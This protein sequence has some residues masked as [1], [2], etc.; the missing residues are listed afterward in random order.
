MSL[1][2]EEDCKRPYVEAEVE[3]VTN[4]ACLQYVHSLG[5]SRGNVSDNVEMGQEKEREVR[6]EDS[7]LRLMET[8]AG[9]VDRSAVSSDLWM[10]GDSLAV[11]KALKTSPCSSAALRGFSNDST[12]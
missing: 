6:F 3:E 5:N 11:A 4:Q 8:C 10:P 1:E 9:A 7:V 2:M 12:V